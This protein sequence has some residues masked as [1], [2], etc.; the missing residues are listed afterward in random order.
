MRQSRFVTMI[1]AAGVGKSGVALVVFGQLRG[2]YP[3][4]V[5]FNDV[6][7]TTDPRHLP[8]ALAAVLGLSVVSS[9]PLRNLTTFLAGRRMLLILAN[10]EHMVAA[11]AILAETILKG[12][13]DIAIIATSREPL[14]AEGEAVDRLQPMKSPSA[15]E[16]PTAAEALSF[17]SVQLFVQPAGEA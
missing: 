8:A 12:A 7:A 13:P 11:T 10:C 4:G 17:P 6:A 15:T 2:A 16:P 9:N 14:R 5:C 3:D 1:G